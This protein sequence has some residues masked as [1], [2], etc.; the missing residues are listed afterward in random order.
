MFLECGR[1]PEYVKGPKLSCFIPCTVYILAKQPI[2]WLSQ[3]FFLPNI[4]IGIGLKKK[5]QNWLGPTIKSTSS[6][7][8]YVLRDP[9]GGPR[10]TVRV[11]IKWKYPFQ[12][13]PDAIGSS[14]RRREEAQGSQR[15]IATPRVK[16]LFALFLPA[17]PNGCD[18]STFSLIFLQTQT[19]VPGQ[20]KTRQRKTKEHSEFVCCFRSR[21][22]DSVLLFFPQNCGAAED[23][24][25]SSHT[26]TSDLFIVPSKPKKRQILSLTFEPSSHVALDNSVQRVFVEYRLLGVPME[27]TETP[28]SLRK[29]TAGE[30]IHY[31]F[32]RV[33]YVDGSSSAP[34]RRYLY[35]MLEG[36]DPNRRRL[37]FTIVSEP[38]DDDEE[39]AD[40][41]Y[42]FLDLQE[43]L[44]TGNDVIERQID[45]RPFFEQEVIGFLKVSVEAAKALSGI[46]KEFQQPE[47]EGSEQEEEE[48]EEEQKEE[49]D[50]KVIE[51]DDSDF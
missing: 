49:N 35:T 2:Y 15:P 36:S 50:I 40:V 10:G 4:G 18:Y 46:Y 11:L 19:F 51:D 30:E 48:E 21:L 7:G 31:N 37:K 5:N 20:P 43:L 16:V 12:P 44:L 33:I 6:P 13:P 8:D 23:P 29:P 39:C 22:V 1:K 28:L 41:G 9:A 34:L 24:S 27:T 14:E 3:F 25:E 47:E 32:T 45:S 42:A 26:S 38:M 17:S